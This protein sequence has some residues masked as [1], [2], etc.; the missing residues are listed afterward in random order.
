MP[1]LRIPIDH[2]VP[3][4]NISNR[5]FLKH[6]MSIHH[7][8]KFQVSINQS[9]PNKNIQ[10]QPKFKQQPM[11]HLNLKILPSITTSSDHTWESE[12]IRKN[13]TAT[14]MTHLLIDSKPISGEP[15]CNKSSND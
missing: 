13:N 1:N 10:F 12:L 3:K 2:R 15:I 7:Q 5:Q 4:H 11:N 6:L 14:H 9:T 8:S